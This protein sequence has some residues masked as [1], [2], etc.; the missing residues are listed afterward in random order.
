MSYIKFK[1]KRYHIHSRKTVV[2]RKNVS[3]TRYNQEAI[4]E[5]KLGSTS[6]NVNSQTVHLALSRAEKSE[7]NINI[8]DRI[9]LARRTLYAL[10]KIGVHGS[11]GLHPKVLYKVYQAYVLPRLL[12]SLETLHLNKTPLSQL[13]RFHISTL[14]NVQTIPVRTAS[15]AVQLLAG[16][17]PIQA[18]IHRRQLNQ[19]HS[20][21]R[22][23]NT[24]LQDVMFRQLTVGIQER[25]FCVSEYILKLYDLPGIYSLST[26]TETQLRN[27]C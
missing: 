16:A 9:S 14:R 4:S 3:K 21:V 11:N 27:A 26:C 24:R 19:L 20:I 23:N 1:E 6:V 2:V 18:E 15:S 25:F 17:L 12:Y 10:I 13:Q 22:S 7:N 5:W 8:S